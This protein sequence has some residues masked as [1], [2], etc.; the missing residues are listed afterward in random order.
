MTDRRID[1]AEF[2]SPT[3]FEAPV[4]LLYGTNDTTPDAE[5]AERLARYGENR[6]ES[7]PRL[8]HIAP[9]FVSDE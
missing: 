4:R 7:N 3:Q 2:Q 6:R 8:H 1:A 9:Q 5:S